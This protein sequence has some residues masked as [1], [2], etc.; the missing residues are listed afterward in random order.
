ML[1]AQGNGGVIH[2]TQLNVDNTVVSIGPHRR[3]QAAVKGAPF[4]V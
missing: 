3:I 2:V 4:A 1:A